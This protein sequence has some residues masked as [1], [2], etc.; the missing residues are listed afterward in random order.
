MFL[1]QLLLDC[2]KR[3]T[4]FDFTD[5]S[6]V[7]PRR[8]YHWIDNHACCNDSAGPYTASGIPAKS[9]ATLR[10]SKQFPYL[11]SCD[12]GKD[13]SSCLNGQGNFLFLKVPIGTPQNNNN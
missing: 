5:Q 4:R 8:W 6:L 12:D 1:L 9:P 7:A 3:L 2:P 13:T 10:E 11:K